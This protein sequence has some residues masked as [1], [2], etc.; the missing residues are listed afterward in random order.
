MSLPSP[1]TA[2]AITAA[3]GNPYA[4]YQAAVIYNEG[5]RRDQALKAINRAIE[6][7]PRT[8]L[9]VSRM[10]MRADDDLASKRQDIEAALR[11][12]PKDLRALLEKARLQDEDG[13][14]AGAL[15]TLSAALRTH[16]NDSAAQAMRGRLLWLAGRKEEALRD[17]AAAR[18]SAKDGDDRNILCWYH[19]MTDADLPAALDDCQA[20]LVE[21][22]DDA[23][24]FNGLAQVQLRLGQYDAA[25]AS[26]GR[27]LAIDPDGAEARYG[28]AI[29]WQRKG[30]AGKAE[31]DRAAGIKADPRIVE[32]FRRSGLTM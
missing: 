31:A 18:S 3:P 15:A 14:S 12:D 23:D 29:A 19:A 13:E 2:P 11:F 1:T 6:I 28:R 8:D 16:P 4:H 9:F 24:N 25:I 21:T 22:P 32:T 7:A 5:G 17:F 30:D 20:A 26:Y 10:M 27:A